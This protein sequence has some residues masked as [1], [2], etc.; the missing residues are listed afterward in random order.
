MNFKELAPA[1]VR[2]GKSKMCRAGCRAGN[3]CRSYVTVLSPKIVGR[4]SFF[5]FGYLSLFLLRV[6]TDWL[7]SIHIRKDNLL[8]SDSY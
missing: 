1:I 2:A 3:S 7:R 8:Y 6:L 5:I 4:Q